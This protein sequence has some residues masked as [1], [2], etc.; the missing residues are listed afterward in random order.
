MNLV[1][2]LSIMSN[3]WPAVAGCSGA[4]WFW[5]FL[6][7]EETQHNKLKEFINPAF[8]G[9]NGESNESKRHASGTKGI[10][11]FTTRD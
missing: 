10:R 7:W 9:S 5:G 1:L 3:N 4:L 6:W 8:A 11:A 2:V